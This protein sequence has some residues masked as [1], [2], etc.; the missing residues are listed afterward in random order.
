MSVPAAPVPEMD[1]AGVM[2]MDMMVVAVLLLTVVMMIM[3]VIV[4]N[5][6]ET[7]CRRQCEPHRFAA[8]ADFAHIHF[9]QTSGPAAT[10]IRYRP[11][12]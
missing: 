3:A 9:L 10:A 4:M 2:V 12:S 8:A 5:G 11:F 6:H 1:V 7:G